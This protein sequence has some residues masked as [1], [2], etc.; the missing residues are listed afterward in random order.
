[1]GSSISIS[2]ILIL[3]NVLVSYRGLKDHSFYEKYC[4]RVSQVQ[5][6]KDYKRLVTS[7]FLHVNW[8]HLI[9]NMLALFFFS[10]SIEQTLG[11]LSFIIIYF[12]SII[13]GNLLSLFIHRFDTSYSSA[14]ASGAICGVIFAAIATLP[15]MKIGLFLLPFSMPGWLFGLIYVGI[16]IYGVRSRNDN[17]GHDAHLGGGLAGMLL[18]LLMN[19]SVIL[20]NYLTILIVA[21]PAV[22]FILFI[23]Y[24]P[25]ALL[26]DNMFFKTKRNYTVE[27]RYNVT[28]KQRQ[29]QLDD[30][31][32]KIHQKGMKSLTQKEKMLLKEYSEKT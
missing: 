15:G 9:F 10:D 32:E 22:A 5:V 29:Q 14:G 18:A 17:I 8:T 27:D 31:L 25:E 11:P 19:P 16:S 23:I 24:K 20:Q 1:M 21:L 4:F 30:I 2:T 3:I 12:A 26:I 28:K 13:G 6:Q 7:A